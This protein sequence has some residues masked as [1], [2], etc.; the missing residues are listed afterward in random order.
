MPRLPTA[1]T[2]IHKDQAWWSKIL[3]G[4]AVWTTIVGWPIAEGFQL[5]SI[6][7]TQ[8]G[9][10]TP[11]PRWNLISDKAVLGIFAIVIDFFYFLFPV[12]CGG[13]VFF[14]GTLAFGLGGNPMAARIV[15]WSTL[16]PLCLYLIVVWLAGVSAVAKQRY[17]EGG[18]L[19]E[20]LS[21]ALVR[22]LLQAPA[23]AKYLRARVHSLP[24]YFVAVLTL[25]GGFVLIGETPL[26]ALAVVWLGLGALLYARLITIQLYAEAGREVERER[27]EALRRR[28]ET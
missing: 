12:V 27:F 8:R 3:I 22:Q 7:N 24:A 17:V 19:A 14:C 28:A 15:A 18:D 6:D 10:P 11:L 26:G 23:R 20:V 1:V 21:G 2:T 16:G 9:F 4:G 13:I 5:E 25:I